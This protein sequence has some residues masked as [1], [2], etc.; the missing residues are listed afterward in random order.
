MVRLA[1]VLPPELLAV[2]VWLAVGARTVGI[3]E[4]MPVEVLKVRPVG[5]AGITE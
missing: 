5:N 2:T 3:P 1:V 4:M